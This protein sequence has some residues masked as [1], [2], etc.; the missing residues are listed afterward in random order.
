MKNDAFLALI[1]SLELFIPN[2]TTDPKSGLAWCFSCDVPHKLAKWIDGFGW[3][4]HRDGHIMEIIPESE[5]PNL[6]APAW[7]G[8]IARATYQYVRAKLQPEDLVLEIARFNGV[9]DESKPKRIPRC[10]ACAYF[11]TPACSSPTSSQVWYSGDACELF[12]PFRSRLEEHL[13]VIKGKRRA[14]R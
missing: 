10:G 14:S 6:Y 3:L 8:R 4:G 12:F 11:H 7:S 13:A 2:T 9:L 1:A 5:F